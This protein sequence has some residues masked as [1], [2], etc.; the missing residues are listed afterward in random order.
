MHQW[1]KA[2]KRFMKIL[3]NCTPSQVISKDLYTSPES[4]IEKY[5]S[6]PASEESYCLRTFLNDCFSQAA[7]RNCSF[8]KF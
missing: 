8:Q 3:K 2:G 1:S 4:D 5:I 7:A 6:M